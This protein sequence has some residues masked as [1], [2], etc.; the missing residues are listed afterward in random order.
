MCP[1]QQL[2]RWL[3]SRDLRAALPRRRSLGS[4]QRGAPRPTEKIGHPFVALA[5]T[6]V[7][8]CKLPESRTCPRVAGHLYKQ[9]GHLMLAWPGRSRFKGAG[10][11]SERFGFLFG[12]SLRRRS[13][14]QGFFQPAGVCRA[15][16]GAFLDNAA[17]LC[18]SVYPGN[19][20]FF[21]DSAGGGGIGGQWNLEPPP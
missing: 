14:R 3:D 9:S 15:A 18:E 19:A 5:D 11:E 10:F 13:A 20:K 8:C 4:H 12:H 17:N 2:T 7:V 16:T 21:F 1:S 6:V